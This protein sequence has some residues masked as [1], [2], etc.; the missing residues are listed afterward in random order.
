[1]VAEALGQA[2]SGH[3]VEVAVKEAGIVDAGLPGE[4]LDS[5]SG[6][7]EDGFIEPRC[8]IGADPENLQIDATCLA[9]RVL[10]L[11]TRGRDIG[12]QAVGTLD[13]SRSK[14][15]LETNTLSM[16][17]IPLWMIGGQTNVLVECETT[18]LLK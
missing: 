11:R 4:R 13:R 14:I 1:M 16:T 12:S 2:V 3:R 18:G 9:Y 5:G 6:G 15:D 8:A 10:V 17:S 7:G